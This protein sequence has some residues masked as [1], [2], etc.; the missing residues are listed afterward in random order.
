M[1]DI[2]T[3]ESCGAELTPGT[4]ICRSCGWDLTMTASRP[5]K[6]SLL[7]ILA[8]T[9]FRIV[10]YGLIVAI[11]VIGVIRL[12][13]TG[14]GPDLGTT[15][16]WM[17]SGDDGRAAELVTIHRAHETSLAASRYAVRELESPDFEGAWGETLHP[18]AT[19]YVR[20][21]IPMLFLGAETASA[22]D[23]LKE[24][25]EVKSV[26]GWGSPYRVST[27]VLERSAKW[28]RD[29]EVAADLDAGLRATFFR[30]GAPE[31]EEAEWLRLQ[32]TSGGPDQLLDTD[33]DIVFISYFV[34]GL[35]LRLRTEM[36][37]IKREIER[38]YVTGRHYF[39]LEGNR[40]TLLD[41]RRLAEYRAE[42]VSD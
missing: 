17:V 12:H 29:P 40:Y 37:D 23:S 24:I 22:P 6:L 4:T 39:R 21:W 30:V 8:G 18:Y 13:V 28:A 1:S 2:P 34:V 9:G 31:F 26:D 7:A 10:L 36:D 32:L 41:A 38:I 19:I 16:R 27:R 5:K 3:C 15:I 11:P 42:L 20:G 14:P 33:D 25:Y 35:T